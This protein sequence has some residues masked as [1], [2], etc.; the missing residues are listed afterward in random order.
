MCNAPQDSQVRAARA[1]ARR[2]RY[3]PHRG[4]APARPSRLRK[5]RPARRP[6]EPTPSPPRHFNLRVLRF[7]RD[8]PKTKPPGFPGGRNKSIRKF[9]HLVISVPLRRVWGDELRPTKLNLSC[10]HSEAPRVLR[11]DSFNYSPRIKIVPQ[12]IQSICELLIRSTG[13]LDDHLL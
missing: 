11:F 10:C 13:E 1:W 12:G 3:R 6:A 4:R 5:L 8:K 7:S 9:S 2:A